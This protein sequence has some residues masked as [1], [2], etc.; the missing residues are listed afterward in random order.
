MTTHLPVVAIDA[1]TSHADLFRCEPYRVSLTARAC[2]GRRAETRRKSTPT[3]PTSATALSKCVA[4]PLGGRVEEQLR[5]VRDVRAPLAVAVEPPPARV[6]E[7]PSA[8]FAPPSLEVLSD[9]PKLRRRRPRIAE[10]VVLDP[11]EALPPG[12]CS[13]CHQVGEHKLQCGLRADAGVA[14]AADVVDGAVV[15]APLVGV[16]EEAPPELEAPVAVAVAVADEPAPVAHRDPKPA[17]VI[18]A[19]KPRPHR[20]L[21]HQVEE[22]LRRLAGELF[23]VLGA[24]LVARARGRR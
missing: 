12:A 4:C 19:R 15:V 8:P 1:I 7:P 22:L 9:A 2:V 17:K 14:L 18:R 6:I 10:L 13:E 24:D 11:P 16:A 3:H 23:E 21:E 20:D 5:G